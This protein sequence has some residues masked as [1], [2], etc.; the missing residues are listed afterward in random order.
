MASCKLIGKAVTDL[1]DKLKDMYGAVNLPT[2]RSALEITSAILSG[3]M[4]L[5]HNDIIDNC[6]DETLA[7]K[8]HVEHWASAH[9]LTNTII[10]KLHQQRQK[11]IEKDN[12]SCI[13]CR[14]PV[15]DDDMAFSCDVS[16]K[17]KHIVCKSIATDEEYQDFLNSSAEISWTRRYCV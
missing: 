13:E 14:Q 2:P 6:N 16:E 3:H 17:W 10:Y 1:T 15:R 11:V 7:V 4:Y 12:Y 5:L 8:L 9:T